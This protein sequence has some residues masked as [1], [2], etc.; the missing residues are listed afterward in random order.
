[1]FC[2][3]CGTEISFGQYFCIICGVNLAQQSTAQHSTLTCLSLFNHSRKDFWLA[4]E[5]HYSGADHNE[6]IRFIKNALNNN[7]SI[8]EEFVFRTIIMSCWGSLRNLEYANNEAKVAR[9]IFDKNKDIWNSTIDF[10]EYPAE[11]LFI[12]GLHWVPIYPDSIRPDMDEKSRKN[13][14]LDMMSAYYEVFVTF[15]FLQILMYGYYLAEGDRN[16]AI[17]ELRNG[18]KDFNA[19]IHVCSPIYHTLLGLLLK[20]NGEFAQSKYYLKSA[21]ADYPRSYQL[22]DIFNDEKNDIFMEKA[23]DALRFWEQKA[24]IAIA[25]K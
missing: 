16:K 7:V 22:I 12:S 2:T 20:E 18:V 17:R 24:K 9:E 8:L 11:S 6:Q 25:K 5:A 13:A 19:D 15:R 21:L 1:M 3:K 23:K 4:I 14:A 10:I